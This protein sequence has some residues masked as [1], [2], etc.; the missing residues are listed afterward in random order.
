MCEQ[1][2]N[3]YTNFTLA[4][5]QVTQQKYYYFLLCAHDETYK[6]RNRV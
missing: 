2:R 1:I 4:C 3:K 6:G 5:N